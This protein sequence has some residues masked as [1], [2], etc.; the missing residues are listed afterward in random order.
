M[1]YEPRYKFIRDERRLN[2][3][4]YITDFHSLPLSIVY[5][6]DDASDQINVLNNLITECIDR[7]AP[8]RKVKITRPPSPWMKDLNISML[9]RAR[10]KA[11][12]NYKNEPSHRHHEELKTIGNQ[13]KRSIKETKRT[14][15]KKLLLN[16]DSSET[17][18]VITK[19]LHPNSTSVKINPDEV[20]LTASSTRLPHVRREEKQEESLMS[21]FVHS[22]N[23]KEHSIYGKSPMTM[24]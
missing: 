8:L 6:L 24:W 2:I 18:K 9:Q 11:R 4:N 19:I 5:A 15:L 23:N 12:V 22:Q 13:L 3:E 17:W 7:H 21:F 1:K 16:K 10:N 20:K 14:F